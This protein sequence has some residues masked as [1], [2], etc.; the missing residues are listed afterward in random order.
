VLV[1]IT[2]TTTNVQVVGV[3]EMDT[4]KTDGQF[5]YQTR[6]NY[7]LNREEVVIIKA[8]PVDEVE[9][10]LTFPAIADNECYLDETKE[11][12]IN[13]SIQGLYVDADSLIVISNRSVYTN[14]A[15]I[16]ASGEESDETARS[17]P[18]F[19]DW[20]NDTLVRVYAKEDNF[21]LVDEYVFEGY[22]IGTRKINENLF[23]ITSKFIAIEAQTLITSLFLE[24]RSDHDR[25]FQYYVFA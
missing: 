17:L 18:W 4:I 14:Y 23:V 24:Q 7:E 5:I 21:A 16:Q 2:F 6:Y 19:E 15:F 8:W 13:E 20:Q 10:V 12:C 25:V 9:A 3:D 11:F 1:R 22:M